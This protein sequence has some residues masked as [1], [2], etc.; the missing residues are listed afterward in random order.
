R[1]FDFLDPDKIYD[2]YA[3]LCGA[4][5][6]QWVLDNRELLDF[7]DPDKCPQELLPD[8]GKQ[9]GLELRSDEEEAVQREKITLAVPTYKQKGLELAVALRLRSLGYVGQVWEIWINPDNPANYRDDETGEKGTDFIEV[10][11]GIENE[12]PRIGLRFLDNPVDEDLV[13]VTDY[14]STVTFEFESSGG[15]GG[16]NVEV[17]IGADAEESRDNLIAAINSAGLGVTASPTPI[18][19]YPEFDLSGGQM[20]A[21]G[22]AL[23]AM[24]SY[25]PSSRVSLH[26]RNTDG[27]PL[28]MTIPQAEIDAFKELMGLELG[29]DVLPVCTDIRVFATDLEVTGDPEQGDALDV[30]D[31][32]VL[33]E[34]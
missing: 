13:I 27:T 20:F 3:R 19:D 8:L 28:D 23:K 21:Q 11:H 26:V 6:T 22:I 14:T 16:G 29:L 12:A 34:V 17:T 4:T 15:V 25:Y 10:L 18:A 7:I 32:L 33:T 9:Y 30:S 2:Y 31:A 5:M 1:A 24:N